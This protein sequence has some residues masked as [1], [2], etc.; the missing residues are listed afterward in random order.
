MAEPT[1]TASNAT[2]A[3]TDPADEAWNR[4]QSHEVMLLPQKMTLP[5]GG[6]NVESVQV[7]ALHDGK[8]LALR[9]SWKSATPDTMVGINRFRDGCA[10]MF[11]ADPNDL[12]PITMGDAGKPVIV[13]QWKPDWEDPAAQEARRK[14]RYPEYGDHYSPINEGLWKD[15]G[16]RPRGDKA[17]VLVAEGFG[18]LTRTED[19]DL[20]VRSHFQDGWWHVVFHHAMPAD[21][22]G[23]R[24]GWKGA[25][26]VAVWDGSSQE[27]GARKSI[28]LQWQ[29]LEIAES[30]AQAMA[31]LAGVKPIA[32]AGGLTAAGIA[33]VIRRRMQLAKE[34]GGTVDVR[35]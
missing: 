10:V 32:V 2:A 13:W 18:T 14:D 27:V 35:P 33:W 3:P 34:A 7:R 16:D 28:S 29:P 15:V 23:I 11:P 26:N 19:P 6:G 1:I 9:L 4:A 31:A 12:P 24:P 22:P 21:Y 25:L 5:N 17:N 8:N 30:Q 20:G